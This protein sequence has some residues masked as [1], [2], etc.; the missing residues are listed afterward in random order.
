MK[1]KEPFAENWKPSLEQARNIHEKITHGTDTG[2]PAQDKNSWKSRTA[3][4]IASVATSLK[5]TAFA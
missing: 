1:S 5:W 4:M 3:I 2:K